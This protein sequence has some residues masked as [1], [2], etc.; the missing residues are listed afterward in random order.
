MAWTIPVLIDSL[1]NPTSVTQLRLHNARPEPGESGYRESLLQHLIHSTPECLP[2]REIEPAFVGLRSVCTELPLRRGGTERY[3]D[4]LLIN[5]DGRICLAE[6][7]LAGNSEAD[8]DVLAQL[9][10]YA[11]SLAELD[12]AGLSSLVRKSSGQQGGDPIADAVLGPESDAGR[13]E[14]LIAGVERSLKRAEFLLLIGGIGSGPTLKAW[15][16]C[17]RAAS[18]WDLPSA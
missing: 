3:A 11:A 2:V 9:L 13:R 14:D 7:K 1:A 16:A 17:S 15:S 6:C 10:D 12:Y 8:R 5:P 4:N 18:I